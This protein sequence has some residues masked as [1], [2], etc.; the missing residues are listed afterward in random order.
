LNLGNGYGNARLYDQAVEQWKKTLELDPNS[1]ITHSRLAKIY[2][3]QGHYDQWLAEWK[4]SAALFKTPQNIAN[5]AAAERGYAADG[6]RAAVN[7][8][9]QEQLSQKAKGMYVDPTYIAYN[10]AYLG[11]A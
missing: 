4:I 5:Q 9:I 6:V 1:A 2:F 11:D 10:Y 8:V 3:L 7:A